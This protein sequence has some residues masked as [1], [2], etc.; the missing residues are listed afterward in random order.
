M[1]CIYRK[2]QHSL[3][4]DSYSISLINI[5][6]QMSIPRDS[7]LKF[8]GSCVCHMD[9]NHSLIHLADPSSHETQQ[10]GVKNHL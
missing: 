6:S 4:F 10:K 7:D 5:Y 9:P 2:G 1:M 3:G 8:S